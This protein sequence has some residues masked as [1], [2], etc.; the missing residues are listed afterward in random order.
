MAKTIAIERKEWSARKSARTL[1]AAL[2][3]AQASGR[4]LTAVDAAALT[5]VP[6]HIAEPAL[7]LLAGELRAELDSTDDG[8][9]QFRFEDLSQDVFTVAA[10]PVLRYVGARVGRF[11]AIA[12]QMATG[13]TAA[14][15]A[16]L[17]MFV[18]SAATMALPVAG[19]A[20]GGLFLAAAMALTLP[21]LIV[22]AF[23]M[24]VNLVL[25]QPTA[26]D[27]VGALVLT[28][29]IGALFV[30]GLGV[31]GRW[32][33]AL[34]SKAIPW[35]GALANFGGRTPDELEDEVAFT[36]L[37][38][39]NRGNVSLG[40]LMILYGWSRDEAFKQ[41]TRLAV[42]YDGD[43]EV[44]DDG[45]LLFHFASL[46]E[47]SAEAKRPAPAWLRERAPL[48]RL[49]P[50]GQRAGAYTLAFWLFC[51]LGLYVWG[52]AL[53]TA[54]FIAEALA[55]AP[56]TAALAGNLAITLIGAIPLLVLIRALTIRWRTARFAQRR[57]ELDMLRNIVDHDGNL[58]DVAT[59]T[60]LTYA[61]EVELTDEST[62]EV[63]FPELAA[64]ASR[65]RKQD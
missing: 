48:D 35:L 44:T 53:R 45:E 29:P 18:L 7:L 51:L 26:L 62:T 41:A 57:A 2:H 16:G 37:A 19:T 38:A 4:W 34:F 8:T 61:G 27:V 22:P 30:A 65:W 46:G 47:S 33:L 23:M 50:V 42:D 17:T 11:A 31:M 9:L 10:P 6:I 3:E 52:D 64:A 58:T 32:Y 12:L 43:V 59:A 24:L 21:W 55:R 15:L 28:L 36:Q 1:R 54:P 56:E 60:V 63:K 40:D 20:V 39:A 49:G 5:G 25:T 13:F 14:S